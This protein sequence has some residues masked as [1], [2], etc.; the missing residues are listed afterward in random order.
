VPVGTHFVGTAVY[1]G[2]PVL[3]FVTEPGAPEARGL[4]VDPTTCTVVADLPLA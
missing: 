2:T 4:L 1:T 3:A